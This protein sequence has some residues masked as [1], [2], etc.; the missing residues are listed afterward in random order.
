[1]PS[2]DRSAV[3]IR[4]PIEGAS[5]A[6]ADE[7]AAACCSSRALKKLPLAASPNTSFALKILCSSALSIRELLPPTNLPRT[8]CCPVK[9]GS[10]AW[11][12]AAVRGCCPGSL[13]CC[14]YSDMQLDPAR[15][16]IAY[17]A[18][19]CHSLAAPAVHT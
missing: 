6:P 4:G 14:G 3:P 7:S 16:S 12:L 15:T 17:K 18:G 5:F 2:L 13:L 9:E 10:S 11:R 8:S 1:M 19:C